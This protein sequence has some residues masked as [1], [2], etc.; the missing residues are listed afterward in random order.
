MA[1]GPVRTP[2]SRPRR[3][4]ELGDHRPLRARRRRGGRSPRAGAAGAR[5]GASWSRPSRRSSRPGRR[6]C[7]L[8]DAVGE[9]VGVGD[10]RRRALERGLPP[11]APG[12]VGDR[13]GV[14]QVERGQLAPRAPRRRSRRRRG[15][16]RGRGEAR[17][18]RWAARPPRPA[19]GRW[20]ALGTHSRPAPS[21]PPRLSALGQVEQR[22]R[23]LRGARARDQA[24]AEE[25]HDVRRRPAARAPSACT[26][27]ESAPA[28]CARRSASERRPAAAR[29]TAP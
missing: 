17:A 18:R 21:R 23:R 15:R 20:C 12:Q 7:V 19:R 1:I 10:D 24:L 26:A 16:R 3:R 6:S 2:R 4:R 25:D 9:E 29:P 11:G 5:R 13:V 14:Q 28:A 22:A 27:S 8:A